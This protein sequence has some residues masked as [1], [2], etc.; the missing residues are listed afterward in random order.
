MIVCA[1]CHSVF[2]GRIIAN[3]LSYDCSDDITNEVLRK[4]N[5]NTK[6]SMIY[7][8]ANLGLDISLLF[9]NIFSILI[10]FVIDKCRE[11]EFSSCIEKCREMELCSCSCPCNCFK[12]KVI[13]RYNSPK[14]RYNSNK[15]GNSNPVAEVVVVNRKQE[16]NDNRKGQIPE[17]N[18]GAPPIAYPGINSNANL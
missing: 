2:L 17:N 10:C 13:N 4:E 18:Y 7:T 11:I 15:D 16:N 3:D 8:A 5:E 14:N 1:I 9:I 12:K 6:K